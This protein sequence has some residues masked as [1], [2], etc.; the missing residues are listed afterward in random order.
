MVDR[1]DCDVDAALDL[2]T[3][4]PWWD[5]PIRDI[6]ERLEGTA[7]GLLTREDGTS[8]PV[9]IEVD[10]NAS[11]EEWVAWHNGYLPEDPC[12]SLYSTNVQLR[13]GD[14]DGAEVTAVR[15]MSA[16]LD[17]SGRLA[18]QHYANASGV[19]GTA[20]EPPSGRDDIH[21]ALDLWGADSLES[22][23]RVHWVGLVHVDEP[24][25]WSSI[26]EYWLLA[27]LDLVG[28]AGDASR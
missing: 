5:E 10:W 22:P 1:T 6:M 4:L 12:L 14:V 9:S 18:L 3:T 26:Q 23:D 28:P 27:R 7:E 20:L 2:D 17:N 11:D 25:P 19:R 16:T 13:I 21:L 15:P 8:S 24:T